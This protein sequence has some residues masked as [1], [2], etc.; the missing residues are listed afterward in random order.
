MPDSDVTNTLRSVAFCKIKDFSMALVDAEQCILARPE[1]H[2][3]STQNSANC[4]VRM[5]SW[6]DACG[7][8]RDT[9]ERRELCVDWR[10][11]RKLV[12]SA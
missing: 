4:G 3:V 1:W 8:C 12:K 2:K 7:L 5:C 9:I 11:W 10:G 6:T